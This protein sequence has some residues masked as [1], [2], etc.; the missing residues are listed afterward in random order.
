M[1]QIFRI[2]SFCSTMRILDEKRKEVNKPKCTRK[3]IE[4]KMDLNY[5]ILGGD[6]QDTFHDE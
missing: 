3:S 2:V 4:N 1:I 5:S 6:D